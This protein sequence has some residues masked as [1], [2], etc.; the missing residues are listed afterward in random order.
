MNKTTQFFS[1]ERFRI[2][3]RMG[4]FSFFCAPSSINPSAISHLIKR[5]DIETDTSEIA[6]LLVMKDSES[7]GCENFVLGQLVEVS[8]RFEDLQF[9][10]L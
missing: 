4:V 8:T 9:D 2:K 10:N 6:G 5:H 7:F 3:G 1:G